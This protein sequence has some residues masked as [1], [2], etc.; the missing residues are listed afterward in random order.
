MLNTTASV[1]GTATAKISPE[2]ARITAPVFL[3]VT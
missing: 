3:M 1:T 2:L